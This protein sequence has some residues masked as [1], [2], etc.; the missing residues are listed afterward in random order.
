MLELTKKDT[1]ML[2]G[3]E[4]PAVQRAMEI[5][6]T[7]AEASR[8]KKLLGVASV[9]VAGVS[10]QNIGLPGLGF[11]QEW[12]KSGAQVRVPAWMNPC[13]MDLAAWRELGVS[14]SFAK[15]QNQVIKA[16]QGMGVAPELTCTPYQIGH[17]PRRGSH[18]AWSES[19]AV[20]CANSL[21]GART[22]REGGPSAL[23]AAI[24][25]RTPL[26]GYHLTENRRATH[27]VEVAC[28]ARTVADF[29]ALGYLVGKAVGGGVPFFSGLKFERPSDTT[30]R[31]KA[32]AAAM[33][34]S[35]A[36]ALFHVDR[37]TPE[38]DSSKPKSAKRLTIS[39]L[40]EGYDAL[41][42]GPGPVDL[43]WIG[44]PHA[45]GAELKQVASMLAGYRVQSRLWVTVPRKLKAAPALADTIGR[46]EAAGGMVV[47]DTCMV[48]AP[49]EDM[50]IRSVAT[51]SAK[52]ALYLPTHG[53]VAVHYGSLSLCVRAAVK[54][55][56][57]SQRYTRRSTTPKKLKGR[58]VVGGEAAAGALST[59]QP[60]GFFGHVDPTTGRIND[61]TH[62]LH[63]R[64]VAGKVLVFPHGKGSTVGS[65]V[66]YALKKNDVAP[67]AILVTEAEPIVAVGAVIAGIPTVSG[68]DPAQIPSGAHVRVRGAEVEVS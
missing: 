60:L 66:M 3:D 31:L 20:S 19:S 63:G 46:I 30:P 41:D 45:S 33:A 49:L 65:Y 37:V 26:C 11:L 68:I 24:T 51:N 1:Q 9:Q 28:E 42:G 7:L 40:Q 5:I 43:A 25:G 59:T 27:L 50:G 58:Q 39:S 38:A 12:A 4:G 6:V 21:Y 36:V 18:L 23:A 55:D 56:W 16:L 34:A 2:A 48:V 67:A 54:G 62:E 14:P 61:P 8:A 44:C 29:G 47:A 64:S 22:N 53:G 15:S 52:G 10:F 32:L 17:R 35:G 13:G 57:A